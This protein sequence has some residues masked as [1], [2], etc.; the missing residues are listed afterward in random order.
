MRSYLL[1]YCV[2]R[3]ISMSKLKNS[4][5]RPQHQPRA[6]QKKET[7]GKRADT[8]QGARRP[9]VSGQQIGRRKDVRRMSHLPQI[10]CTVHTSPHTISFILQKC[11]FALFFGCWTCRYF[12]NR[13]PK[14]IWPILWG[15]PT[16]SLFLWVI[17]QQIL[18]NFC[19]SCSPYVE[20]SEH[21]KIFN[22]C[23]L[24]DLN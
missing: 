24:E 4:L 15:L 3:F 14:K 13:C 5:R 6:T 11:I 19:L 22:F 7:P 1:E 20:F 8:G 12:I 9:R 18:K 10:H 2:I 17:S 23:I 21:P 16:S